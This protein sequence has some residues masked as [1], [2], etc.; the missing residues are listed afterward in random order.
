MSIREEIEMLTVDEIK[1]RVKLLNLKTVSQRKAD[2]INALVKFLSDEI[3]VIDIWRDLSQW[4]KEIVERVVKIGGNTSDVY[5]GDIYKKYNIEKDGLRFGWGTSKLFD[6]NS[7]ANVFVAKWNIPQFI[8]DILKKIFEP[9]EIKF[10]PVDYEVEALFEMVNKDETEYEEGELKHIHIGDSYEKDF[11]NVVKLINTA[12]LKVTNSKTIPNKTA[13]VKMNDV[14]VN[15][16]ILTS[17]EEG[18]KDITRAEKSTRNFAIFNLLVQS[19]IITTEKTDIILDEKAEEFLSCDIVDKCTMLLNSYIDS[20][21]DEIDRI[22]NM[23]IKT[24]YI[25]GFS[26]IRNLVVDYVTKLPINAW[27]NIN[28]IMNLIRRDKPGVLSEETGEMWAYYYYDRGYYGANSWSVTRR[29][30]EVILLEYLSTLGLIDLIIDEE[31]IE[32]DYYYNQERVFRVKYVKLTEFGAY[33]LEASDE[34][35]SSEIEEDRGIIVQPNFEIMVPEGNKKEIYSIKLEKFTEKLTDDRMS[36]YKLNFTSMIKALD[37]GIGIDYII[38]Y[39][40]EN[41][42]SE[43]P[44]NVLMELEKWKEVSKRIKIRT[45]TIVETDDKFLFEELKSYKTI[46]KHIEKDLEYVFEIDEKNAS[47]VKREIEK[48][49]HFCIK[50]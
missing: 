10:T 3:N 2:L 34:Y 14:L 25:G 39:L 38:E 28:Q 16:E 15:K 42:K 23:K 29:V 4:D 6:E 11:L 9:V 17:E 41:T 50:K 37:E 48:K 26:E 32:D 40:K 5:I 43:I 31:Y 45:V 49:G 24:E 8:C 47:K 27:V 7:K 12:K 36:I 18:I 44:Q 19:G 1:P 46:K 35:E 20:K 30:I 33:A 21:L 13:L 22:R